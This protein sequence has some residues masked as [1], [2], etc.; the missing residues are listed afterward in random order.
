[1]T[2]QSDHAT[3]TSPDALRLKSVQVAWLAAAVFTVAAGFGALMPVMP[4]WLTLLLPGASASE[5]ARHVGFLSGA[6]AVGVL[7]GVPLWGIA[8]D[9]VGHGRVLIF[10][11]VGY[12]ASSLLRLVPTFTAVWG[13]YALRTTTGFFVAAVVPVVFALVAEHTPQE[14]RARRFA[15]LGCLT[16]HSGGHHGW[17]RCRRR[18]W[19]DNRL[20]RGWL[21]LWCV[22]PEKLRL[23]CAT[24]F[25]LD[26]HTDF[27]ARC[28]VGHSH[29]IYT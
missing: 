18:A 4:A 26:S 8:G 6:Y 29:P 17:A 14:Q 21:A 27:A 11:L 12:V 19:P 3:S 13:M 15:W 16:T 23:A 7:V 2:A 5:V 25:G 10:G 28:M 1:M 9:H 22:C 24:V 20:V